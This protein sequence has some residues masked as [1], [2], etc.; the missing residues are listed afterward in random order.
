MFHD[1]LRFIEE[2]LQKKFLSINTIRDGVMAALLIA[3]RET[4]DKN[5]QTPP[6]ETWE[7]KKAG[8]IREKAV[9]I[10]SALHA[11]F[12]YPT[13]AQLRQVTASLKK[14]FHFDQ[15][16]DR[17]KIDFEARCQAFFKKYDDRP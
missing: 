12:E 2:K 16:S 4:A 5:G 1:P 7:K 17:G 14:S 15:F 10:F 11:P 3:L 6:S 9:E 13:L 8:E